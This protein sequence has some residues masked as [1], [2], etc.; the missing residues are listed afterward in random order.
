MDLIVYGY[1]YTALL[2]FLSHVG[3]NTRISIV[4]GKHLEATLKII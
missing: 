2:L 3:L 4:A 1:S